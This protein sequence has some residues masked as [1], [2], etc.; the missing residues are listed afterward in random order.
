[1]K[2]YEKELHPTM[3]PDGFIPCPHNISMTK[4]YNERPKPRGKPEE[5]RAITFAWEV[6]KEQ[7]PFQQP[8]YGYRLMRGFAQGGGERRRSDYVYEG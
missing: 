2:D 1:M 5:R 8:G 3:G 6:D 7:A 4:E